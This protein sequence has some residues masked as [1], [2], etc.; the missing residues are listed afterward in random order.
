MGARRKL[1]RRHQHLQ[2]RINKE[3]ERQVSMLPMP[4]V[5]EV[6]VRAPSFWEQVKAF[7]HWLKVWR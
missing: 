4:E 2:S 5:I 1:E 7:W 6:Q 3:V